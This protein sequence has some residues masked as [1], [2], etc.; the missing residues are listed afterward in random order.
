MLGLLLLT[1][2]E[3]H[4]N[5]PRLDVDTLQWISKPSP[6]RQLRPQGISGFNQEGIGV[7]A[8][9]IDGLKQFLRV[10]WPSS[11]GREESAQKGPLNVVF[12]VHGWVP[13][14]SRRFYQM[15][16]DPGSYYSS[17]I[18]LLADAGFLVVS[19][20]L[21]G[22]GFSSTEQADEVGILKDPESHTRFDRD[23]LGL[24]LARDQVIDWLND[25]LPFKASN[26]NRVSLFGHS[27]GAQTIADIIFSRCHGNIPSAVPVVLWAGGYRDNNQNLD[28]PDSRFV[29][30][31]L[32]GDHDRFVN[33]TSQKR[34]H[35]FLVSN[36][37]E[38]YYEQLIGRN[39]E[40]TYT[41]SSQLVGDSSDPAL[42][43]L[44]KRTIT[45]LRS[46]LYQP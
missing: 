3:A 27:M 42:S 23:V 35:K 31:H 37:V 4:A 38:S 43:T 7:V 30:W 1:Q 8:V 19:P 24:W 16:M 26:F 28:R 21:R 41:Q 46:A 14:P 15:G 33:A 40:L 2:Q 25:R 20:F 10:D 32:H 17:I 11:V 45:F 36:G 34:F 29:V 22:H 12:F 6:N 39:H 44:L 13:E 5:C 9:V 18:R